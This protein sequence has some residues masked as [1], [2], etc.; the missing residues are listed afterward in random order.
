ML[1]SLSRSGWKGLR[2]SPEHLE[3]FL[4][5]VRA[6]QSD[7]LL[8]ASSWPSSTPRACAKQSL[9]CLVHIRSSRSCPKGRRPVPP[10]SYAAHTRPLQARNPYKVVR[11]FSDAWCFFFA[12][13]GSFCYILQ[14]SSPIPE[15][16]AGAWHTSEISGYWDFVP[17]SSLSGLR[18]G[19]SAPPGKLLRK[20]PRGSAQLA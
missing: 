5:F 7:R 11:T 8:H 9:C 4:H 18:D 20:H 16:A 14:S 10:F 19:P 13:K 2:L 15:I 12:R 3:I 17:D 6:R 1:Q